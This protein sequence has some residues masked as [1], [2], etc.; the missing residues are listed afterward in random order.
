MLTY[1][2]DDFKVN[3]TQSHHK[4]QPSVRPSR[5]KLIRRSMQKDM[6]RIPRTDSYYQ[7]LE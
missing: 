4:S 1:T 6:A 7:H 5:K 3:A 2:A